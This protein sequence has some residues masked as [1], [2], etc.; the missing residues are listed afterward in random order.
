VCGPY[1]FVEF[2]GM[3]EIGPASAP[4]SVSGVGEG[5]IMKYQRHREDILVHAVLNPRGLLPNFRITASSLDSPDQ[6]KLDLVRGD[7]ASLSA[8][9]R[10]IIFS[11]GKEE[12]QE[13]DKPRTVV[14]EVML[15]SGGRRSELIEYLVVEKGEYC[16]Q[17]G[18]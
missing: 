10:S 3:S 12:C 17:D 14:F 7:C 5:I 2:Q 16:I 4:R 1:L 18:L 6:L 9:G 13:V 11:V 15:A 8:D